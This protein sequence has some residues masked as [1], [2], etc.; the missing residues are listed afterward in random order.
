[1]GMDGK[2]RKAATGMAVPGEEA[3]QHRASGRKRSWHRESTGAEACL[4]GEAGGKLGQSDDEGKLLADEVGNRA[5]DL[6]LQP[7]NRPARH[8]L[9]TMSRMRDY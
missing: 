2:S 3:G 9:R 1:V 5:R 8:E 7:R 6:S 4:Q